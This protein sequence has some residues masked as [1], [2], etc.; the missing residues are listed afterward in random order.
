M[1]SYVLIGFVMLAIV[2]LIFIT[3]QQRERERFD[4]D[5]TL[6]QELAPQNTRLAIIQKKQEKAQD[7]I[8]AGAGK[9]KMDGI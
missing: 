1:K 7:A 2:G 8:N 5:P 4:V 3:R 6:A 9:A